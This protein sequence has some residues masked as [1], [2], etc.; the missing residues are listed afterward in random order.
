MNLREP[1]I[2]K[3]SFWSELFYQERLVIIALAHRHPLLVPLT[4]KQNLGC[5]NGR[6]KLVLADI[7]TDQEL[8]NSPTSVVIGEGGQSSLF[9]PWLPWT[10]SKSNLSKVCIFRPKRGVYAQQKNK[11]TQNSEPCL[12]LTKNS[13]PTS[14]GAS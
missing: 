3:H 9:T 6:E 2:A 5:R 13:A 7:F 14:F 4:I 12:S 10:K 11:N 8:Q 1:K